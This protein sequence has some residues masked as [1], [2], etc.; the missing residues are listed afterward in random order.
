MSFFSSP[1]IAAFF[2]TLDDSGHPLYSRQMDGI[3]AHVHVAMERNVPPEQVK[4]LRTSR[5]KCC[6]TICTNSICIS[7]L[8][9]RVSAIGCGR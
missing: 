2:E 7:P 9:P 3:Y 5:S 6:V 8:K 1:E 4:R